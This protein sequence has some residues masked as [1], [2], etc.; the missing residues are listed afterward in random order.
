MARVVIPKALQHRT[1]GATH[2]EVEARDVRQL[3]AELDRRFP[4]IA[5]ELH[6]RCQIAV[7]G[8]IL[9]GAW[10]EPLEAGSE[11]HFL[12]QIGGG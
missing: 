5:E 11:V 4:G 12:P 8:D 3:L 7:D 9:A 1:G 6:E 2:L 10:L